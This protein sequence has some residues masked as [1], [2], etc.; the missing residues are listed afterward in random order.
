MHIHNKV[1]KDCHI[2]Q[3]ALSN[4]RERQCSKTYTE[5]PELYSHWNL[6]GTRSLWVLQS[7]AVALWN[8]WPGSYCNGWWPPH[9]CVQLVILPLTWWMAPGKN[10][11]TSLMR[12]W[13]AWRRVVV[14]QVFRIKRWRD[15]NMLLSLESRLGGG[16]SKNK[17]KKKNLHLLTSILQLWVHVTVASNGTKCTSWYAYS[18]HIFTNTHN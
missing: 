2:D 18:D 13:M 15:T 12:G 1:A 10:S 3:L 5:P 17:N 9:Y 7:Q 8:S 6:H 16:G 11:W 4:S 14:P